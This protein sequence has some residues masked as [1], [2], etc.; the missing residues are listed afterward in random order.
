MIIIKYRECFQN[1]YAISK[2]FTVGITSKLKY[3]HLL[4]VYEGWCCL[5]DLLF[6][7]DSEECKNHIIQ[8]K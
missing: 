5:F 6:C 2:L 3:N 8:T 1:R 4:G 7:W